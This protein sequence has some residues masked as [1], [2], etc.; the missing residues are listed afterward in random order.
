MTLQP[1]LTASWAIQ[2]HVLTLVL[3]LF[4][5]TWQFFISRK[6]A[7]AHR[8]MGAAFLAL[9]VVSARLTLFIRLRSPHNAFFGLSTFHLYVPLVLGL[10]G[11]ALYG[12]RA[13]KDGCT[14]SPS[15]PSI[16]VR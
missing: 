3:A 16:L 5:G 8:P 2:L 12:A 15:S 7:S 9:M 6:G 14:G 13:R 11:L 10:C 1:L 4:V